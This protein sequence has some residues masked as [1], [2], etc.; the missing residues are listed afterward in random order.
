MEKFVTPALPKSRRRGEGVHAV[1]FVSLWAI[2]QRRTISTA[3]GSMLA[4]AP[5]MYPRPRFPAPP[6]PGAHVNILILG[7]VLQGGLFRPR[8]RPPGAGPG[9]GHSDYRW[10]TAARRPPTARPYLGRFRF[11]DKSVESRVRDAVRTEGGPFFRGRGGRGGQ[12]PTLAA[13]QPLCMPTP[14]VITSRAEPR[15][16]TAL[17]CAL[18]QPSHP[19]LLRPCPPPTHIKVG[20]PS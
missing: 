13:P 15:P 17:T 19:R 14:P 3:M 7:P 16:P 12:P 8:P 18:R 6:T 9:P 1:A 11:L 4:S 2:E 20:R 5:G 10:D